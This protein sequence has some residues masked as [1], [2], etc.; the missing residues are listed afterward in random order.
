MFL[1]R[2]RW[3]SVAEYWFGERAMGS[4]VAII[5]Q[6]PQRPGRGAKPFDTL[7]VD[8]RKTEDQLLSE[9]HATARSK[10]RR[11]LSR[12]RLRGEIIASPSEAEVQ[13]F[14]E[15]HDRFAAQKGIVSPPLSQMLGRAATGAL[16]LSRIAMDGCVLVWHAYFVGRGR[17]RLLFSATQP[18]GSALE[19]DAS[20]LSRA[21]SVLHWQDML[22]FR[23]QGIPIYDLGGIPTNLRDAQ[24]VGLYQFKSGFGG[25]RVREWAA[26]Q[27]LTPAGAALLLA[28]RLRRRL[29]AASRK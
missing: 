14:T 11:G 1:I 4:D 20:L 13:A 27:A 12:D 3:P 17:V 8:L 29:P 18:R 16:Q 21:N 24:M 2:P 6:A 22:A 23:E 9:F 5:R 26:L 19:V 7:L 28:R 25:P 10:V 15:F